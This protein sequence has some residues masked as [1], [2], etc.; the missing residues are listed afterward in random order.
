[1]KRINGFIPPLPVWTFMVCTIV[2]FYNNN[3]NN[4]NN[5]KE[6]MRIKRRSKEIII[7]FLAQ[8]VHNLETS[9]VTLIHV[10]LTFVLAICSLI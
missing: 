5:N 7:L 3:N 8:E 10:G 2:N 6:I 9:P 4:N 1:V